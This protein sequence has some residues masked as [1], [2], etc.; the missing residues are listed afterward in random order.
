MG[1]PEYRVLRSHAPCIPGA[2]HTAHPFLDY[3]RVLLRKHGQKTL[4]L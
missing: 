4:V 3:Q 2:E 1:G